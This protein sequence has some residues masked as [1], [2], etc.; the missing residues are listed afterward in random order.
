MREKLG[1]KNVEN[2]QKIDFLGLKMG[3]FC[4]LVEAQLIEKGLKMTVVLFRAPVT[5]A[6]ALAE[7]LHENDCHNVKETTLIGWLCT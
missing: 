2:S 4:I 7:A 1:E 5:P 3:K 6:L